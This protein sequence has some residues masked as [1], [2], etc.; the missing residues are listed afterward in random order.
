MINK[1]TATKAFKVLSKDDAILVD[2][3]RPEELE[4]CKIDIAIN[5][6]V[7][8]LPAHIK[9]LPKDKLI[10]TTCASGH[11]AQTAQEFLS[12]SGFDAKCVEGSITELAKLFK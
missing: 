7:D 5:I 12:D 6:P 11:R 4:D 1:I 3:R 10:I 9:E 2:V 8:T